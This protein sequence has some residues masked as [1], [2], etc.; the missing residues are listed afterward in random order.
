M[1]GLWTPGLGR[2]LLGH[3]ANAV[4]L[5]RAGWRLRRNGWMRHA[6]FLPLPDINYW[7]FRV[8]TVIG[9]AGVMLS[10]ASMVEAAKWALAQPVGRSA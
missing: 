2:Y 5:G 3:P 7:H 9:S 4:T 6:P 1:K 8:V 10:P